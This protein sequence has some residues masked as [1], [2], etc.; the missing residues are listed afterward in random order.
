MLALAAI[1][2]IVLIFMLYRMARG[3]E[4]QS[5]LTQFSTTGVSSEQVNAPLCVQYDPLPVQYNVTV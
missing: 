2:A 3:D 4:I 5:A 1:V